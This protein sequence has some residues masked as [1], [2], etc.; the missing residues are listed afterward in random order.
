[1]FSVSIALWL[2]GLSKGGYNDRAWNDKIQANNFDDGDGGENVGMAS[3]GDSVLGLLYT[4]CYLWEWRLTGLKTNI[5]QLV[6][7]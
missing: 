6:Y 2:Y 7:I 3:V 4:P 5:C 1:M